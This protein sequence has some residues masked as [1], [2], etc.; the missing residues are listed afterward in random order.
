LLPERDLVS[1]DDDDEVAAVDVR[2][3][4]R[5]VLAAQQVRRLHSQPA[6]HD[7]GRVD[8]VPLTLDVSGLGAVRTHVVAFSSSSTGVTAVSS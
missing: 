6:E 5:L 7:V 1:V 8:D 3:E 4:R 2:R